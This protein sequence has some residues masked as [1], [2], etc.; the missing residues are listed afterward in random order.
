MDTLMLA[1]CAWFGVEAVG[2]L[3][4]AVNGGH[5]VSAA[6]CSRGAAWSMAVTVILA[7]AIAG[8]WA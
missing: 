1:L 7:V 5:W 8:H 3:I 6:A 4:W 2:W